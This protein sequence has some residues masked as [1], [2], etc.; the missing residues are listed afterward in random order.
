[1]KKLLLLTAAGLILQ[2]TPVLADHHGKGKFDEKF[3]KHDINGDGVV[4]E[5]EFLEN[6]KKKF[7]EKDANNDGSVS[8]DEAKAAYEAKRS[9][10]K[11]KRQGKRQGRHSKRNFNQ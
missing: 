2:A 9:E 6:A 5:A 11:E 8:K 4:S 10:R 7:S 1:M 3:A